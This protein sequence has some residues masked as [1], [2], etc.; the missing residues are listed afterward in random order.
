MKIAIGSDHRGFSL[1]RIIA[2]YL[3]EKGYQI[4]DVGTFSKDPCDYPRYCFKV[5]KLV[6]ERKAQRGIFIC[7]TGIGSCIA[8]N[9]IK[10]ARA[11]LVHNVKG[12]KFSRLHNDSNI[13]VLGS[14]FVT[15]MSVKKIVTTW[16]RTDFEGGRHQRRLNQIKKIEECYGF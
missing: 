12:A 13:L 5:A 1:K 9:K 16:L 11:A 7:K 15:G 8:L 6:A 2:E 3:K 4:I 10:G 14:D